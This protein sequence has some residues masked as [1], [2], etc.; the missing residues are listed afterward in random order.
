MINNLLQPITLKK[1]N[2]FVTRLFNVNTANIRKGFKT[3]FLRESKL[4]CKALTFKLDFCKVKWHNLNESYIV[5][6]L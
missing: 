6:D 4:L 2:P 1:I 5:I 3:L